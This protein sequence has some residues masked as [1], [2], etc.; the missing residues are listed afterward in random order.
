MPRTCTIGIH[1][2]AE[3]I[4]LGTLTKSAEAVGTNRETARMWERNDL[5]GFREKLQA[6]QASYADYWLRLLLRQGNRGL[7]SAFSAGKR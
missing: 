3:A 2:Q 7:G 4:K 5:Y 6:A 1:P